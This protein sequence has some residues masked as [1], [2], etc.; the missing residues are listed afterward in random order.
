M[1]TTELWR[2]NDA[3]QNCVARANQRYLTTIKL[4]SIKWK[5]KGRRVGSAHWTTDRNTGQLIKQW[6]ELSEE[7]VGI[8]PMLVLTDTIPHEVAHLVCRE[9]NN[10]KGHGKQ[11]RKVCIALGGSGNRTF[12]IQLT[13]ARMTKQYEYKCNHTQRLFWVGSCIHK[14]LQLNPLLYRIYRHSGEKI[15]AH[16]FTGNIRLT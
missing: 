16:D 12:A 3:V 10:D 15:Y 2:F 5:K 9:L 8:D 6:I 11:W 1:N 7:A 4:D 14:S 13:K